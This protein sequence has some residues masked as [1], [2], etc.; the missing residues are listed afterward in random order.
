MPATQTPHEMQMYRGWQIHPFTTAG[1]RFCATL[2]SPEGAEEHL[3]LYPRTLK[4]A[5]EASKEQIDRKLGGGEGN[6]AMAE[7]AD[8]DRFDGRDPNDP[9]AR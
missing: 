8:R 7:L 1:G 2:K 4:S 5:I 6:R 9:Q 3:D